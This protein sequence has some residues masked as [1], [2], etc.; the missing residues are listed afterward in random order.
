[1]SRLLTYTRALNK[2]KVNYFFF[3]GVMDILKE[4]AFSGFF[5]TN[6]KANSA[7]YNRICKIMIKQIDYNLSL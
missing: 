6:L 2:E 1:M 5:A 3:V 7:C 4:L